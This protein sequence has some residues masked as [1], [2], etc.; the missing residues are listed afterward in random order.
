MEV[1]E[2]GAKQKQKKKDHTS[3]NKVC[4]YTMIAFLCF[5]KLGR[6]E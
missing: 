1:W 4:V 2:E 6:Y 5:T 3:N